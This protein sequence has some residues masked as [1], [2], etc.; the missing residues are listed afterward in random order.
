MNTSRQSVAPALDYDSLAC[1]A[2]YGRVNTGHQLLAMQAALRVAVGNRVGSALQRRAVPDD[3]VFVHG[4]QLWRGDCQR[5]AFA[6][7]GYFKRERWTFSR[8]CDR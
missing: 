6:A 3:A 1:S 2:G 5:L 8:Y 4:N 7:C